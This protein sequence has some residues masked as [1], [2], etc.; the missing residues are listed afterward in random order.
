MPRVRTVQTSFVS[1]EVSPKA[2]GR[3]DIEQYYA[4]LAEL[5]NAYVTTQGGVRRREGLQYV[6]NTNGDA[7]SRL[8]SF[9]FNNV[10]TYLL[11]FQPSRMDVYKDDV[12]Q[13]SVTTGRVTDLTD[14]IIDEMKWTQSA[15][16]L[17]LVHEDLEPIKITRTSDTSWTVESVTFDFIPQFAFDGTTQTPVTTSL[18]FDPQ[19]EV[20]TYQLTS[21]GEFTDTDIVGQQVIA[22]SGIFQ[23]IEDIDDDN[24]IARILVEPADFDATTD[25]ILEDGFEDVWSSTRGWPATIT[26]FQGRLWFGGG[27]RPQTLWGSVVGEFFNFEPGKGDA[28]DAIDVTIDDDRVNAILNIFPGRDLQIFTTGGEFFVRGGAINEPIT[29]SN[30]EI[31]RGT[32]HGSEPTTPVSID[33]TV[34]FVERGGAVIR[35]FV[36]NDL[37]QT[38]VANDVSR[39]A[40]HLIKSPTRMTTRNATTTFPT[41]YVYMVSDDGNLTVLAVSRQEKII[42]FSEFTTEGEFEDVVTVDRVVYAIVKRT[43]DGSTVRHIEKFNVDHYLDASVI[44]DNGSPTDTWTGFDHL[45]GETIQIRADDFV[46]QD[47]EV[48]SGGFTTPED[49]TVLEGG[50]NF[51]AKIKSLPLDAQVAGGQLT[52]L[53]KRLVKVDVR[54]NESRNFILQAT[55]TN[56]SVRT[57][58]PP[59]RR[60]GGGVLDMAVPNFT[61]WKP[62]FIGGIDRDIQVT[63]T[64]DE[65]LEFNILSVVYEFGN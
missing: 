11:V 24:V 12:L 17:I 56:G 35:E 46:F 60:F 41:P 57:F 30:V 14:T 52:G 36:F 4:G 39:L 27:S 49:A 31:K 55:K 44:V 25:W 61:G 47:Q 34:L 18:S 5:K 6:D 54:C 13:T 15:D 22:N 37:E 58:R 8:I 28:A 32:L 43:I 9:E 21:V 65:P 29:P 63:I 51:A 10:Q 2:F 59:F 45:D 1:G 16:T 64:Q 62:V 48:A 19:A 33:G 3:T 38:F 42:A 50:I 23:I 20:D 26:F 53:Y 7:V 40:E